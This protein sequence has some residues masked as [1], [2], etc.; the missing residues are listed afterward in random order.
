[1]TSVVCTLSI[2]MVRPASD[3]SVGIGTWLEFLGAQVWIL[4]WSVI[5]SPILLHLVSCQPLDLTNERTREVDHLRERLFE[6]GE[7]EFMWK[8]DQFGYQP[9]ADI[10]WSTTGIM[11]WFV[12]LPSYYSYYSLYKNIYIYIYGEWGTYVSLPFILVKQ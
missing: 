11:V 5:I 8:S 10:L 3:S 7:G 9:H 6:R 2:E 12:I 4:V 1:M